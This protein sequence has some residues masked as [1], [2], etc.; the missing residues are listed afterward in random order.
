MSRPFTP[1]PDCS[2]RDRACYGPGPFARRTTR[3]GRCPRGWWLHPAARRNQPG[4]SR[5]AVSR[6]DAGVQP[7]SARSTSTASRRWTRADRAGAANRRVP[8]PLR[9]DRRDESVPMRV[10]RRPSTQLPMF[11]RPGGSLCGKALRSVTRS[12][13]SHGR[14]RGAPSR[15]PDLDGRGRIERGDPCPRWR[16]ARASTAP[17]GRSRRGAECAAPATRAPPSRARSILEVNGCFVRRPKSS[18]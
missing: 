1:W 15:G 10:P 2:L 13:R 4:A 7:S 16:G 11:A 3:F 12:H 18:G 9:A 17:G 14:R 5:R 6:R 8:G